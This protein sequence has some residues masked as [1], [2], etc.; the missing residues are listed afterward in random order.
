MNDLKILATVSELEAGWRPLA[1]SE[2]QTA[3]EL[4]KRASAKI[5]AVTSIDI[6]NAS[7]IEEQNL[8]TVCCDMVRRA[9]TDRGDAFGLGQQSDG[10]AAWRSETPATDLYMTAQEKD[11]IGIGASSGCVWL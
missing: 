11:L 4:L 2:V 8:K 3:E 5:L 9:M 6:E 10:Y 1:K 7:E